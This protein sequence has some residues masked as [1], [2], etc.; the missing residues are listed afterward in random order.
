MLS[1]NNLISRFYMD[2][3]GVS[4]VE[5]AL[6]LAFL[7]G[8]II[9]AADTLAGSVAGQMNDTASCFQNQQQTANGGNGGGTGLGGGSG[10][11]GGLGSQNGDGF[12][13]C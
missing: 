10:G 12:A 3:Q 2:E 11:S 4:S 8:G 5:Y 7:G 9:M 1:N 13:R 6:L